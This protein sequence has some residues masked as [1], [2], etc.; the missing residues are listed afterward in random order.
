MM[1]DKFL[2]AVETFKWPS[3]KR[4]Y[5][6]L[7]ANQMSGVVMLSGDVHMT[8]IYRNS[9]PSLT[10]Q[11]ELNEFSSSGLS[12]TQFDSLPWADLNMKLVGP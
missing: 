3:R 7:K 4:L 1:P 12:H 10:G 5:D 9:C 2:D 11:P 6:I 8:Q